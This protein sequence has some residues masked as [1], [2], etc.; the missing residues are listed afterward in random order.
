VQASK[1]AEEE[2][3]LRE[4]RAQESQ[5]EQFQA[6]AEEQK[7]RAEAERQRAEEQERRAEAER[8]RAEEQHLRAE[9]ERER[10]EEQHLRAEAERQRAAVQQR[11]RRL[12]KVL[13]GVLILFLLVTIWLALVEFERT[14]KEQQKTARL[15]AKQLTLVALDEVNPGRSVIQAL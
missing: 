3:R 1:A 12:Q 6:L 2:A 9:A 15:I 11:N 13:I 7:R 14:K 10:A 4:K 8:E 5:L